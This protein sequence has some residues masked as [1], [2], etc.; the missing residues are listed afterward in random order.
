MDV[1]SLIKERYRCPKHPIVFCHGLFGFDVIGPAGIKPLQFAYWIGIREALEAMGVEVL[2]GRVPASASIEERAKVLCE[3]IEQNFSGREVNLI[4]HSMGGLDGRFLISRL[5]PTT[6]KVRSLTTISTPHRGSSFADY[7]LEDL[8]GS[9]RVP[10]LVNLLS[11]VGV[12]GGGKAFDDL[13]TTKM[14]RFNDETPDDPKVKY[15]SYGAEFEPGW[16]NV[17][18][19]P[20]GI[21]HEREGANDGLV[22]IESAKW[23]QYQA[24]LNNVNHLDL[25]GWV[26][27][28]RYGWAE[29]LGKPIKFK[30]VSFF[31]A[32][33]EMLADEDL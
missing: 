33:A 23:G 6:F 30:P 8:L 32:V 29:W 4:G 13:T 9:Q 14:A 2:I 25:V 31:C 1:F 22:S 20:W 12:P 18:R 17:F 27:K 16:S 21:V 7:L 24:T 26:G 3:L 5:Q 28:V 15:F 10:A 19:V 11:T